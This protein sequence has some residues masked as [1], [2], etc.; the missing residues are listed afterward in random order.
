[1][2]VLSFI[3]SDIKII[4]YFKDF[5]Q[6]YPKLKFESKDDDTEY[7]INP[8]TG[9][10][11]IYFHFIPNDIE[12]EFEYNYTQEV[13]NIIKSYFALK[14]LMTFDIQFKDEALLDSLLDGFNHYLKSKNP[15][16]NGEVLVSNPQKGIK[17]LG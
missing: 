3:T 8:I 4:G 12:K 13:Q 16:L 10:N 1:M 9:R 6:S 17:K 11:E 14:D 7:Y 15:Q 2:E 5:I